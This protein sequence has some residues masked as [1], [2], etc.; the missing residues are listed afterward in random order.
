MN[1]FLYATNVVHAKV[2][3]RS[4]QDHKLKKDGVFKGF[5]SFMYANRVCFGSADIFENVLD[6][7]LQKK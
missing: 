1:K 4:V 7:L 2:V 5:M 3:K 6:H